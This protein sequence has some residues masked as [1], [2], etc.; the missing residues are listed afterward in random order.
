MKGNI[1]KNPISMTNNI[2]RYAKETQD[3]TVKQI[4]CHILVMKLKK[5]SNL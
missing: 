3:I 1:L 2:E 4:K 5:K